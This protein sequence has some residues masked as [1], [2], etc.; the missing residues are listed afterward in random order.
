MRK[1][2]V[3]M[4][5]LSNDIVFMDKYKID[6]EEK[7][8]SLKDNLISKK[9]ELLS[10]KKHLRYLYNKNKDDSLLTKIDEVNNELNKLRKDLNTCSD[11]E[12]RTSTISNQI[13]EYEGRE[14]YYERVK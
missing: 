4:D 9:E 3:N 13:K 5:K 1:E 11:I 8:S 2:V 14:K 12:K 10:S 7:L 6:S